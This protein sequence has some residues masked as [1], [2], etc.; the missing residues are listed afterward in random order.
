MLLDLQVLLKLSR[1]A[2]LLRLEARLKLATHFMPAVL[3]DSQLA[4]LQEG[5]PNMITVN[6]KCATI[7]CNAETLCTCLTICLS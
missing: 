6:G 4:A 2:L 1:E 3:L 5:G 7:Q